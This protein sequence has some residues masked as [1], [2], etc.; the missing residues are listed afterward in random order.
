MSSFRWRDRCWTAT[1][2]GMDML[3]PT[4]DEMERAARVRDASYDGLFVL[5]VRTT[6]IFCRPSC[7]ARRPLPKNVE[8]FATVGEAL[9]AGY[10]PCKRCHPLE[11][12]GKP[13]EWMAALLDDVDRD[14]SARITD[15]DLRAR[16]LDPARVRRHFAARYGMTFHAFCRSRRLGAA[17]ARIR[18]GASL[19]DVTFSSGYESASGFR[20]AFSRL[21]GTPPGRGAEAD[22]IVVAWIESPIGPLVTGA[23]GEGVCLLEF[24]DRR[25]LELQLATV[26]RRFDRP[27]VPGESGHLEQLHAELAE[28][29]AGA[30]Q[31]FEVPVTAPGSPFQERV[32]RL[33][34]EIPYGE[35]R[36]YEDL[37]RAL[38]SPGA[39][40]AVGRA[41]GFNRV[42]IVLP[43]H[44]VVTKHGE[45]GGYGGGVWRKRYLL[46][47]EQAALRGGAPPQRS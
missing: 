36:S 45:L 18:E 47:L 1:L 28:Y 35:T 40:R 26:R 37:A 44:R 31:R 20:E 15:A 42:S 32:W 12:G 5:A 13:P 7:P 22:C 17:L 34:R 14:P 27:I 46:D 25:R 29:F 21:F 16:G 19:D 38:G 33:L 24:T 4:T 8:Y 3:T 11:A 39:A 6:G 43:C 41:N 23:S 10:R 2:S 30:R 9:F